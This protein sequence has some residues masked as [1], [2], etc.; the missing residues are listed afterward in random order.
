M[1]SPSGKDCEV[2]DRL[3]A[4]VGVVTGGLTLSQ[5]NRREYF[6]SSICLLSVNWTTKT[7]AMVVLL[8]TASEWSRRQS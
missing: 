4:I 5:E 3:N 8:F 1:C 7:P 6:I 2:I